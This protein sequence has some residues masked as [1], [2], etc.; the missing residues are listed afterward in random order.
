MT[1]NHIKMLSGL[2]IGAVLGFGYYSYIG[3]ASGTCAITSNPYI[4][5]VYGAMMGLVFAW[6]AKEKEANSENGKNEQT[7]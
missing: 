6:P 2:F 4:S 1:K 5:T 7:S 3:C